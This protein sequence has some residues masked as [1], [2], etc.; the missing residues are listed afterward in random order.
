MEIIVQSLKFDADQKLLDFVEKK[1]VKLERFD[2]T[3]TAVEAT[4]SLMEK[5]ENKCVKLQAHVPGETLVVERTAKS[6][7]E[8]LNE[9]VDIMKEKIVRSKERRYEK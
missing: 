7:E 4:L 5:P 3:I 6:F 2:D 8:A 9:S 1:V